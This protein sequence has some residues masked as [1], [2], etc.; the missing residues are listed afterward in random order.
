MLII[1][2]HLSTVKGY[3]AMGKEAVRIGA[4]TFQFFTRNPRGSK[5]KAL[6]TDDVAAFN[7]F[8]KENNLG[9]L[10]GHAAY[11][12][13]PA[14]VDEHQK[15]FAREFMLDDLS[16]LKETPGAMYNFHPGRHSAP[17]S[18]NAALA[19]ADCLNAILQEPR[20]TS[21]LLETMAGHASEVGRN[22]ETLRRIID[23]VKYSDRLGVCLDT[24]HVF[25]AGY[26]IAGD[27][28]AVFRQFDDVIGLD[29]LKAVHLNDSK[30]PLGSR[31]DRHENIGK[32]YIGLAG[33]EKIIN[34]P[35]LNGVAM[36]L[37]THNDPDG[38]GRE[39]ALLKSL[40][41]KRKG[42]ANPPS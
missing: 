27:P 16:R 4:D 9:P 18:A 12:L 19:V 20:G 23:K 24:C 38:Y 21:V 17:D 22:F 33:F 14:A 41:E 28:D 32:G 1:G 26:D 31:M 10:L 39:I 25:A 34:H 30:F 15:T 7:A 13:N 29:R 42:D 35:A 3:L 36:F 8:A 6:N 11:T 2:C 5:A 40:Y 37:E